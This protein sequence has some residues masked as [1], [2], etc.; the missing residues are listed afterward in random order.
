[1]VSTLNISSYNG[2]EKDRESEENSNVTYAFMT[3]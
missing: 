3:Y 2:E 1:M